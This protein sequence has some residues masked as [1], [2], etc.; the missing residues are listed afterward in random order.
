[1]AYEEVFSSGKVSGKLDKATAAFHLGEAVSKKGAARQ[2]VLERVMLTM[3]DALCDRGSG[4]MGAL[5]D[6]ER[7]DLFTY[8]EADASGF[9]TTAAEKVIIAGL[10]YE[11]GG[12]QTLI[13]PHDKRAIEVIL[14]ALGSI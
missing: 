9:S 1:M 10:L 12:Q 6:P 7:R 5:I 11:T 8:Y 2:V 13:I 4:Q 3:Y 14:A